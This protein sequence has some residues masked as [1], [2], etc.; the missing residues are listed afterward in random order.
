MKE[1]AQLHTSLV[2]RLRFA[3]RAVDLT[4]S[5]VD[6]SVGL[7]QRYGGDVISFGM[8]AAGPDAI[9]GRVLGELAAEILADPDN[10]TLNYGPTEGEASLRSVLLASLAASGQPATEET[11]LI[12]SG[13]MQGLDLVCKMFLEPGGVVVT[14]SP[15]YANALVTIATYEGRVV[16]CPTDDHGIDVDAI[17]ELVARLDRTP[18]LFYIIPNH[19]NPTGVTLSDDRRGR[20]IE[21]AR[22]YHAVIL[23]DDPYGQLAYDGATHASLLQLDAGAGNVVSVNTFSKVIAPGLRVGWVVAH[24]EVTRRMV[25]ARHG[26]DTCT[27]VLGQRLVAEFMANHDLEA[28]VSTLRQSYSTKLKAMLSGL[29]RHF[30]GVSGARWTQPTG[31]F[32]VWLRLPGVS[33]DEML[34]VAMDCGVF[35][36]PGSAFTTTGGFGDCLRLN[37]TYP[38]E[39]EIAEGL[40]RLRSAYG[41]HMAGR[42]TP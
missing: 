35:F 39:A 36:I 28:H 38:S 18:S 4:G 29:E 19:Q 23:E 11:L 24:P 17:P 10:S 42:H 7:L 16:E 13:G 8:G 5:A 27:N 3:A 41:K 14:E 30:G 26:M 9:P 32:F 34:T 33:A 12:T 40:V 21:L 6:S 31:G 1:S 15:T 20:L 25:A 2:G 22:R 37:F